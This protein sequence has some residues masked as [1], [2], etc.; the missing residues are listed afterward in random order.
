MAAPRINVIARPDR[1]TQYAG[2]PQLNTTAAEYWITRPSAQLRT[3]RV[4]TAG[5]GVDTLRRLQ[6]RRPARPDQRECD[7]DDAARQPERDADPPCHGVGA[8]RVVQHAAAEGAEEAADL[9]AHEG[10][11]LD[12]R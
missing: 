7:L 10:E 11:P 8:E 4:M 6:L 9:M 2:L 1:A 5:D 3:R 12:H